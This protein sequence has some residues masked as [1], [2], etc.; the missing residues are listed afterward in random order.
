M[1]KVSQNYIFHYSLYGYCTKT[2]SKCYYKHLILKD[3]K[4]LPGIVETNSK[5]EKGEREYMPANLVSDN[6]DSQDVH[7]KTQ[8]PHGNIVV[9]L[10]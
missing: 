4:H 1:K 6:Y 7:S 5:N 9:K 2:T 8:K 10:I 3:L